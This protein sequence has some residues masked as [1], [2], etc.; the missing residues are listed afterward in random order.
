[1]ADKNLDPG[2]PV[3]GGADE[4]LAYLTTQITPADLG[5]IEKGQLNVSLNIQVD[6]SGR[7]LAAGFSCCL[8]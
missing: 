2:F 3:D 5:K 8:A 7:Q 4:K 1:M 6:A